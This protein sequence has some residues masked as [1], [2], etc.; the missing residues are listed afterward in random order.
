MIT[1]MAVVKY[2]LLPPLLDDDDE[3]GAE[4]VDDDDDDGMFW[5]PSVIGVDDANA[6]EASKAP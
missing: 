2:R 3:L 4:G 6:L 1:A 5:N